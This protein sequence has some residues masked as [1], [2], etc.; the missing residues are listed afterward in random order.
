MSHIGIDIEQFTRDPHRSGIQR[1]LQNLAHLWPDDVVNASFVIPYGDRHMLLT[2]GQAAEVFDAVFNADS[3]DSLRAIVSQAIEAQARN[4]IVVSDGQLVSLFSAWLLPE[5]SYLPQVL[6]RFELFAQLMPTTM[7]AYDVL[8]MTEPGNYRFVP[9]ASAHVSR[10]FRQLA[11]ADSV[12]CIS[13]HTQDEIWG[14]LR[15]DRALPSVVAHPGG[16]HIPSVDD[17]A[18]RRPGPMRF[19]RVGTLEAR[20]MPCEIAAAFQAARAGGTDA[21]LTFIGSKSASSAEI[22]DTLAAAV[23]SQVGIRWIEHAEDEQVLDAIADTDFFL[24]VGVEG[25]GIPVLE[26]IRR[27][28]PVLYAGIQPAA[29]IVRGSGAIALGDT[30]FDTL[31]KAFVKYSDARVVSDARL[32]VNPS[33]VPTWRDFTNTVAY[34]TRD[35]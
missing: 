35:A 2:C 31:S 27:G 29:D 3:T 21:E 19:L 6:D 34:A 9:G 30:D 28:T 12:V 16:D 8:P 4:S 32:R 15:R 18:N 26:A 7:I 22:N 33:A 11:K 20:K 14:C 10:Y 17:R 5:V 23:A 25:Y 1:V 13:D 24:S